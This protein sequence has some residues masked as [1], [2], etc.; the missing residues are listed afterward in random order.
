MKESFSALLPGKSATIITGVNA[1]AIISLAGSRKSVKL[2]NRIR[3]NDKTAKVRILK[4]ICDSST[5]NDLIVLYPYAI[6][7][8]NELAEAPNPHLSSRARGFR[9]HPLQR[10]LVDPQQL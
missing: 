2:S 10:K 3:T 1:V 5:N 7:C 9:H 6:N 8:I 4:V